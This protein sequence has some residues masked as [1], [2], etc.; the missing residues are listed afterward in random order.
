[1]YSDTVSWTRG[2]HAFKAGADARYTGS[3]GFNAEDI[4]AVRAF[5]GAGGQQVRGIDSTSIPGLSGGNQAIAQNLLIDL[6]GSI[7]RIREGFSLVDA[8]NPRFVDSREL[9]EKWRYW[10]EREFSV[11]FKDDWKLRQNLTLNVGLRYDYYGVPW[12][13]QGL[14]GRTVGGKGGLF[15][16]SGTSFAD[17]WQPG[18][19]RGS[20]TKVE[21]VGKNSPQPGKQIYDDDWNNFAPAVGF[22]WSLPWFGKDKTILRAGYGVSY[23]GAPTYIAIDGAV[24][25]LPGL[26]LFVEHTTADLL[27][28]SNFSLPVPQ[29]T[30][31]PLEPIPL[32]DRQQTIQGYEDNR[33][34]PYVQNWNLELQRELAHNLTFEAR[35]VGSK[36]TKLWAPFPLNDVNIFENGILDAFNITRAGGDAPLF[37]QMLRGLTMNAG[38]GPVNGT[39]VTGSAALRQNT[40]FRASIANGDVGQF[41][42]LL[43][44]STTVTNVAGGLIRNGGFPH[45]GQSAIPERDIKWEYVEFH[46]SFDAIAGHQAVVAR[47][48]EPKLL[49]VEPHYWPRR[50]RRQQSGSDVKLSQS[51]KYR[52]RQSPAHVS[53]HECHSQQWNVGTSVWSESRVSERRAGIHSA[54]GGA[55]AVWRD[56]QLDVG[57]SAGHPCSYGVSYG[58][59]RVDDSKPRGAV[60]EECWECNEARKWCD[61]L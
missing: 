12:E 53:S 36:A 22:S 21:L 56:L 18:A 38:Q 27:S 57:I 4:D 17:W 33:V 51:E 60:P 5:F 49:H 35:Y 41:A 39:T 24:G 50:N 45:R 13:A 8:K 15:G 48:Y 46:L 23:Q 2:A 11:F 52:D 37:D 55:M 30:A 9:K 28:L 1:M 26:N 34:N 14:A 7:Q 16:I 32:T 3:N 47:I 25:N 54:T 6:A 61:L 20:I 40:I 10:R 44:T 59:Y 31:K 42:N 43:N 19:S 58:K 29:S